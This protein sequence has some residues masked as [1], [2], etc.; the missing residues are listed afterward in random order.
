M[1]EKE[2]GRYDPV[3]LLKNNGIIN[4]LSQYLNT[5]RGQVK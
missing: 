3:K 1:V 4:S 2:Y 5:K